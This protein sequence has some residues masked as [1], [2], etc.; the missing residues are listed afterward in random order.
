MRVEMQKLLEVKVKCS[1]YLSD[2][3][4]PPYCVHY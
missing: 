2:H 1:Y 4:G 3:I